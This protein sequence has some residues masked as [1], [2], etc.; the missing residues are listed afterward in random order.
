MGVERGGHVTDL[1][2][3]VKAYDI[4]GL[5]PDQ[6]DEHVAAAFGSAFVSVSGVDRLV[7]ARDMREFGVSLSR[8]FATAAATAG[9]D[10]ID[11]GL[12]STDEMYFI[13][14]SQS[15]AGAMFTASHNP[16][17]YNGIKLCL[18]GARPISL[19]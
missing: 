18:P 9:A 13:S 5:V 12:C 4:R 8:A 11:A 6:W 10:V 14:G 19:D 7:V 17:G 15:V 3:I 16:S 2:E 1:A